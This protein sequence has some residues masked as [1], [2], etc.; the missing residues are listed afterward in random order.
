M[1]K[2]LSLVLVLCTLLLLVSCSVVT[3]ASKTALKGISSAAKIEIYSIVLEEPL[4]VTD[5]EAI[6]NIC[7]NL[8]SLQLATKIR[9]SGIHS[10]PSW[11]LH[12]F[13]MYDAEG[14][15]THK[16]DI[17]SDGQCICNHKSYYIHSG[18][19]DTDYLLQLSA[20]SPNE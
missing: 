1:K 13:T 14:N 6:A 20:Q 18:A 4:V 15:K 8:L 7:D 16:I 19:I 17:R 11:V 12:S 10:K 5:A 9:L 3:H 2:S